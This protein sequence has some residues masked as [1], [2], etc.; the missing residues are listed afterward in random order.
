MRLVE[1]GGSEGHRFKVYA[2]SAGTDEML[3]MLVHSLEEQHI[4]FAVGNSPGEMD[5][6]LT[7]GPLTMDQHDAFSCRW[8]WFI[9]RRPPIN[10]RG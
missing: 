3:P 8:R 1:V 10:G 6:L 2:Q 7:I 9:L 5:L 4:P